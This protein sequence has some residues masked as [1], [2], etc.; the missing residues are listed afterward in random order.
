MDGSVMEMFGLIQLGAAAL[1][2]ILVGLREPA[3]RVLSAWGVVF[4][5]LIADDLFRVHERVGARLAQDR[6][7]PSL[8][9][10]SAQELGGLVF[11]A[12]SGLLLAGGLIHQHRH[13]SKAA[14]LGSWEVLF[15]V[16]P[17]VVMAV[18]YVMFSVVRPDL[19]HGP[20]GELV[21][22]ARMT[23]KLLTMTLLLLQAVRLSSVRA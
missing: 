16:V 11:W 23:V 20:V 1:L 19:V 10:S 2:F 22:L 7:A 6:L 8:G 4:L 18:G 3:H 12:V 13:S 21:A 9:E 17:F 14:R 5:F 15:T